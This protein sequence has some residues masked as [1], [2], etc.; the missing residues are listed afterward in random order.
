[1]LV[2]CSLGTHPC[3]RLH[4]SGNL[5]QIHVRFWLMDCCRFVDFAGHGARVLL[6]AALFS[7]IS[8]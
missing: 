2:D 5:N 7:L 1:M 6:I 4:L 3:C 8:M